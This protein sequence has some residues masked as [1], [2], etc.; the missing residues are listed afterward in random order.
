MSHWPHGLWTWCDDILSYM[1]LAYFHL[2][3]SIF[4][5]N[6]TQFIRN[7]PVNNYF[8]GLLRLREKLVG[9]NRAI[10]SSYFP[11]H[12]MRRNMSL[13]LIG[14]ERTSDFLILSSISSTRGLQSCLYSSEA[15]LKFSL[16]ALAQL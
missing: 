10:R 4:I 14:T 13:L 2:P 5:P 9:I 16:S 7:S 12:C 6:T 8:C 11:R 15:L 3:I 1:A